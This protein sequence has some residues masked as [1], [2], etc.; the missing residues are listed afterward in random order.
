V[1]EIALSAS[2]RDSK[3]SYTSPLPV[4]D[5]LIPKLLERDF[6]T[7]S[8][9]LLALIAHISLYARTIARGCTEP[10]DKRGTSGVY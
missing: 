7:L 10:Y 4:F 3:N 8:S 1:R 2:A 9:R 6:S 5:L